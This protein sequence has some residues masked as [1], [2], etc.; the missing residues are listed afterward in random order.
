MLADTIS[1]KAVQSYELYFFCFRKSKDS[2]DWYPED[3]GDVIGK[4]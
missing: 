2:F 4:L 3:F 1:T